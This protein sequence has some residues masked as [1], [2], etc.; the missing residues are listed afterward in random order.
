MKIQKVTI[1]EIMTLYQISTNFKQPFSQVL[2]NFEH[3]LEQNNLS[4]QEILEEYS[5]NPKY[6]NTPQ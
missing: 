1:Q 5:R 6:L 2:L 4:V 3:L